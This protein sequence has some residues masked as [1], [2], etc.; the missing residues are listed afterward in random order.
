MAA[1]A[2]N[3]SDSKNRMRFLSI[4]GLLLLILCLLFWK[5]FI[6]Q[7]VVFSNDGPLGDIVEVQNQ[8]PQ[9]FTGAWFDL[10]SIGSNGGMA[11]PCVSGVLRSI[12]GPVGFAKFYPPISLL[13]L[14]IGAW[15]FFKQLK[16]TRLATTL[17]ALAAMLTST[18]FS[19]T[20]WG[21]ASHAIAF[22]LDFFALALIVSNSS[23]TPWYIRWTRLAVAGLAVGLNVIE[24][25]DIGA[26]FSIFVAAFT[27]FHSVAQEDSSPVL[28]KIGFGVGR[29]AVIAIFAAFLA[30]QTIISLVGTQIA[31]IAGTGQSDAEKAA[32]WDFATQWSLPKIETLGIIVPGL[33]WYRMDTAGG[34]NY[35]GGVGRTPALDRFIASGESGQAPPGDLRFYGTGNYAGI[36][37]LLITAWTIGQSFRRQNS[38]FSNAHRRFIW[39]WT[40]V[41]I[42]SLLFSY[43]RFAPFYHLFYALPYFST[44]RNPIKFLFVFSWAITTLF[45]CGI[46]GLSRRCLEVP[47]SGASS[48]STQFK[49]WWTKVRGFDRNWTSICIVV[50]IGS[51]LAWLVYALQKPDLVAYLHTVGFP[52]EGS[53]RG[54]AE[55]IAAFSLH[56][57]GWFIAF[58]A[59]AVGLVA[60]ILSGAFAG[61]RAAWAGVLLGVLLV[62]D[63]GRADL[64]WIVFWD[65]PQKYATNPIVATLS[66]KPYEHRV[67]D[68]PSSSLFENLYRIE[69]MQQLFPYY[70]IQSLDIVQMP[71]MPTDL[72]A[73]KGA[74]SPGGSPETAYY[75]ARH[76]E[77]TNTRFLLGPAAYLDALNQQLDPVQHRFRIVQRFSVVSKPGIENATEYSQLTAV[78][79][80]NGDYA[81]FDF[82]GA[83]P[84][85]R[86]YSQWQVCSGNPADLQSWVTT[87]QQRLPKEMGDAI[88]SLNHTDVAT[89]QTLTSANFDPWKTVL[90]SGPLPTPPVTT[91]TNENQG[92]V[93]IKSYL[94]KHIVLAVQTR[95]PSVLL[96]NDKYD[97]AWH[98]FVDGNSEPLL[99]CNFIM[100]GVY[101]PAGAHT[102]EFKFSLPL[103]PFYVTA[104]AIALGIVLCGFLFVSTKWRHQ[105]A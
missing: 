64:P 57:I 37:V 9:I 10:N 53:T 20:C 72:L 89:L 60:L 41:L 28:K 62:A 51:L 69:W 30:T 46:H 79:A 71:R 65:Y 99:R 7:E 103:G 2:P 3:I 100:R 24:A 101:V 32:H 38:I 75:M 19:D 17:G 105:A 96:L 67:A 95:V 29:V 47:A 11:A 1:S 76:W 43:G 31:G 44:I 66:D 54:M 4:T 83:L 85:A 81:L 36:L 35:W 82:T 23:N 97:P 102:V 33:F 55:A 90:L 59:L 42:L 48:L 63:L 14:G 74:L 16:F 13:I 80:E 25:A 93:E 6:P 84:R 15:T 34:G 58:F 12:L 50:L 73:Y 39:F 86:L 104:S 61:R 8:V 92:T 40:A 91:A 21:T 56:Q 27:L 98:V 49:A 18:F 70:N 26:I 94:P 68:V 5:S 22:G 45:A 78:P 52:D 88:A 77:L 87:L